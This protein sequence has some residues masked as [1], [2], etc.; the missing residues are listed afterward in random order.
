MSRTV[1]LHRHVIP[2]FFW[3]GSSSLARNARS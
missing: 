1:D 2:D 3:E